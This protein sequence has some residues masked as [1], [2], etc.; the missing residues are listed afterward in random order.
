[1]I[2]VFK[3]KIDIGRLSI[4]LNCRS[5]KSRM[6]RFGGGWNWKFGFQA[7]GSTVIVSLLV[8]YIVFRL[9]KKGEIQP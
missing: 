6:G 9:N 1:M 3:K 8:L 4:E 7:G 2:F 5:K